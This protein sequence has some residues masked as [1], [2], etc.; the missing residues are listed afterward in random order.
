MS[1]Q[2]HG[3]LPEADQDDPKALTTIVVGVIGAALL[4]AILVLLEALY[5]RT[6]ESE[7][8]RKVVLQQS[9]ELRVLRAEQLEQLRD[10]RWINEQQGIVAVPIERAMELVV[11]EAGDGR[12]ND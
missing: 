7:R 3:R 12:A 10:Y 11:R 8:E 6:V 1:E 9:E 5:Y 4:V 2:E